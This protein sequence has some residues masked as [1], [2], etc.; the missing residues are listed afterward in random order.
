MVLCFINFLLE[1]FS[2]IPCSVM[3]MFLDE[4]DAK[5]IINK[6]PRV[7]II[8]AFGLDSILFMKSYML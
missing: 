8:N 2:L 3:E 7:I 1:I 6:M 4:T 5:V